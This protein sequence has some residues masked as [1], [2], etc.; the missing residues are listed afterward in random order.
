MTTLKPCP[1]C[2]GISELMVAGKDFYHLCPKC[3]ARGPV[4]PTPVGADE[5]WENRNSPWLPIESAPRDGTGFLCRFSETHIEGARYKDGDLCFLSD[6]D[7][8][9]MGRN[10]PT[11]WQPLPAAPEA[12]Q[13]LKDCGYTEKQK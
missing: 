3:G 13:A 1:F 8:P 12:E 11:H 4:Q 5:A 10:T 2:P 7:S 9:A 6:G